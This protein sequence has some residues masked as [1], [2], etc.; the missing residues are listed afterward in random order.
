MGDYDF[1]PSGGLKLK[2]VKDRKIKKKKEESKKLKEELKKKEPSPEIPEGKSMEAFKVQKTEA[3]K[4]Y[5]EILRQ[6]VSYSWTM[7]M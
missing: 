1:K 5:E 2:G 7:L 4:R 6:R 3:E